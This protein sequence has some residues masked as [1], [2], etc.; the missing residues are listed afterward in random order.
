MGQLDTGQNV[1]GR[2]EVLSRLGSG[3]MADIY[4]AREIG[5][6]QESRPVVL[7]RIL[8]HLAERKDFVTMFLDEARIAGRLD[9][10]NIA[11]VFELVMEN[12]SPLQVVEF[13]EGVS[14]LDWMTLT[15]D[16]PVDFAVVVE[17]LRQVC[18]GLSYAHRL[19]DTDGTPLNIIHRDISPQNLLVDT[20][21]LVKLID[22]GVAKAAIRTDRTQAGVLKGKYPY[23]APERIKGI[24]EDQRSDLFSVGIVAYELTTRKRLFWRESD[25]QT[26]TAIVH[27][28]VPS[29]RR[30]WPEAPAAWEKWLS[31]ALHRDPDL[32][33]E[34]A[35]EM[36]GWLGQ[37]AS[38]QGLE[39]GRVRLAEL[40]RHLLRLSNESKLSGDDHVADTVA[41][42]M[43]LPDLQAYFDEG[44]IPGE[45]L[46]GETTAVDEPADVALRDTSP[47]PAYEEAQVDA[48]PI[49]EV[50]DEVI[51][52]EVEPP[53][54]RRQELR[55]WTARVHE[56][57]GKKRPAVLPKTAREGAALS[58]IPQLDAIPVLAG[59]K[60]KTL[61]QCITYSLA[62]RR[63]RKARLEAI[64]ALQWEAEKL[65]HERGELMLRLGQRLR[66]AAPQIDAGLAR[67]LD[68]L[69]ARETSSTGVEMPLGLSREL[70]E[71]NSQI[72][73]LE[74]D[75]ADARAAGPEEPLAAAEAMLYFAQQRLAELEAKLPPEST[76]PTDPQIKGQREKLLTDLGRTALQHKAFSESA[77]DVYLALERCQSEL[78][79]CR[80][81]GREEQHL[82]DVYERRP[83]AVAFLCVLIPLLSVLAVAALFALKASAGGG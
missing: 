14:F 37:L 46:P 83:V 27:E 65:E 64:Q 67:L 68:A 77:G 26:L 5:A 51:D 34:S 75:V 62:V 66:H 71:V 60:T 18:V 35:D 2:Y 33:F 17:A 49:A 79:K 23:M 4:L 9:H 20:S 42:A 69:D 56:D 12:G 28:D 41:K 54:E 48:V 10:P 43:T 29:I 55:E 63:M 36:A 47:A 82:L 73:Q 76:Q 59:M 21:G 40:S 50:I 70:R 30:I 16:Q 53:A 6:G 31:K 74:R 45:A 3:G 38:V 44:T 13:I 58:H 72:P 80:S 24:G 78:E 22:F 7:K 52:D 15:Q 39:D 8:P 61:P 25:F 19:D 11:K 1:A 32:R 81:R 57:A